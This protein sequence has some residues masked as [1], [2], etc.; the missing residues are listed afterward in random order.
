MFQSPRKK[1]RK[2]NKNKKIMPNNKEKISKKYKGFK[3]LI[4]NSKKIFKIK[5]ILFKTGIK[6][7]MQMKEKFMS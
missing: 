2:K 7:Q 3:K 1:F 6:L 4:N 5:L